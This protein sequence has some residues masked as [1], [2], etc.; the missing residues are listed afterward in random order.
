MEASGTRPKLPFSK[1][2]QGSSALSRSNSAT[3]T[4]NYGN[5]LTDSVLYTPTRNNSSSHNNE[6]DIRIKNVT[7][8]ESNLIDDFAVSVDN[9]KP[10]ENVKKID[11]TKQENVKYPIVKSK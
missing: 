3:R 2:P 4:F 9:D 1:D 6:E 7:F 8:K 11:M 5:F 10:H